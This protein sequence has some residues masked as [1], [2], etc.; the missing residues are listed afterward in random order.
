MAAR[1]FSRLQPEQ[2]SSE[3]IKKRRNR[4][5]FQDVKEQAVTH[6]QTVVIM[7]MHNLPQHK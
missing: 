6:N 7:A 5:N 1:T 4:A 3:Y 2:S